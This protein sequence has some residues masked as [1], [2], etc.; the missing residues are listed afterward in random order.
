VITYFRAD[1]VDG[2]ITVD[3][4]TTVTLSWEWARVDEAYLDPGSTPMACPAMPCT[5]DVTPGATTTYTLRA[6]NA[7]GSAEATVTVEI[8]EAP[9]L[10]DL[11]IVELTVNPPNPG[12]GDPIHA[13]VRVANTGGSTSDPTILRWWWGD[14]DFDLCQ[15]DVP[16][17]NPGAGWMF[18]CDV[19]NFYESYTTTATV[20]PFDTV[21][22]IDEGNNT[23]EF[24]VTVG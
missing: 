22:E 19:D 18:E 14:Q 24:E 5:Y 1:G 15:W 7:A 16:A 13:R 6:I 2:S 8:A 17:T 3:P 4:G 23:Q 9:A 21:D 11:T 20:D 10:P 12:W